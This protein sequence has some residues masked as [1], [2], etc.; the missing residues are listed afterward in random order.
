MLR[1][2]VARDLSI[3]RFNTAKE[4]DK[5]DVAER[6]ALLW[7]RHLRPQAD[8]EALDEVFANEKVVH[9]PAFPQQFHFTL[10]FVLRFARRFALACRA[11]RL[12]R[13]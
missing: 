1:S 10:L 5:D 13:S 4:E 9:R 12:A 7:P 11:R 3:N 2:D 8:R 6:D